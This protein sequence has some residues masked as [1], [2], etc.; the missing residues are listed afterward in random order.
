MWHVYLNP[1][2]AGFSAAEYRPLCPCVVVP[3]YTRVSQLALNQAL[4]KV[5]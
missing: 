4:S 3:I 2:S 5:P 1:Y